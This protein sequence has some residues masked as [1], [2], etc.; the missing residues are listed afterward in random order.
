MY[1]AHLNP[2]VFPMNMTIFTGKISKKRM[3]EEHPL[4]YEQIMRERAEAER[5]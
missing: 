2:E 4:E 3:I 5:P 1:H